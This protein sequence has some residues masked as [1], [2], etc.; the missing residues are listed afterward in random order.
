MTTAQGYL[1]SLRALLLWP[2]EVRWW[3]LPPRRR[4]WRTL[5]A[6]SYYDRP[7]GK[8]ISCP[9]G[10]LVDRFTMAPNLILP[11]G[12]PSGA[13]DLHDVACARARWDDGTW[14]T[15]WD[16]ERVLRRTLIIEGWPRCVVDLYSCGVV[17]M[18]ARAA[19][20]AIGDGRPR[21]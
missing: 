6:S 5:R 4:K 13:S 14:M 18:A 3:P 2:R 20:N 21:A 12:I 7:T 19:W 10:M 1:Y 9:A 15:I 8:L 17:S 16:A 11:G